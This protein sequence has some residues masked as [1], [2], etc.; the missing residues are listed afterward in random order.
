MTN[1]PLQIRAA[2]A[3]DAETLAQLGADTF[4]QAFSAG[5]QPANLQG[6]VDQAFALDRIAEEL[7]DPLA[8]FWLAQLNGQS[9]GY[10]KVRGPSPK[11][12]VSG[13]RQIE[14]HRIYTLE[15]ARGTGLGGALMHTCLEHAGNNAYTT[16]W[17]G[18]WEQNTN[19]IA[20]YKHR[21]FT[22]VGTQDFHLGDDLQTDLIMQLE[23][24]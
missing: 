8:T 3:D 24:T 23:I 6:Y 20:F 19:A 17:L 14:L 15:F 22:T 5:N 10:A 12:C 4:V 1:N 9:A 18:V 13:T 2:Q 11:D 21:G 7:A 16:L